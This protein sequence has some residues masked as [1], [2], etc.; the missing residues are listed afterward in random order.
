MKDGLTRGVRF[1][2]PM[3]A[4]LKSPG[5][6]CSKLRFWVVAVGSLAPAAMAEAAEVETKGTGRRGG[7]IGVL[8][9]VFE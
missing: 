8:G 3:P 5:K 4:A 2:E 6:A 9:T 7:P 1:M